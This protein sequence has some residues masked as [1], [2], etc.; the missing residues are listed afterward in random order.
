LLYPAFAAA[1]PN[2]YLAISPNISTM[3]F[4]VIFYGE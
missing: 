3:V 1:Y 2:I 4:S